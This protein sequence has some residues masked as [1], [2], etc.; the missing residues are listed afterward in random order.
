VS[1]LDKLDGIW[2][3]YEK[4]KGYRWPIIKIFVTCGVL[5][6]SAS[7]TELTIGD[8]RQL[9][10]DINKLA[11]EYEQKTKAAGDE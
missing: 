3:D 8:M 1:V 5:D 2:F 9:A 6:C 7:Y 4:P 10:I 11:D